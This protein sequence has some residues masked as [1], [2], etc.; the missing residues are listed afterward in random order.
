MRRR[1]TKVALNFEATVSAAKNALAGKNAVLPTEATSNF[2]PPSGLRASSAFAKSESGMLTSMNVTEG[3]SEQ[4]ES[5][6][7]VMASIKNELNASPG[8]KVEERLGSKR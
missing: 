2:E 7:S 8:V 5:G 6:T 3:P 4:E 1:S